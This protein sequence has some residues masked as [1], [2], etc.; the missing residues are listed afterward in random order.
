MPTC[1]NRLSQRDPNQIA[2]GGTGAVQNG[3]HEDYKH[4]YWGAGLMLQVSPIS[5]WFSPQSGLVGR[6]VG[7]E[8]NGGPNG[9]NPT[10]VPF[11]AALG[12][13]AI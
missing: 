2:S 9:G 4:G 3:F 13:S 10:I 8:I 12:N 5:A 7:S 1:R 11:H 6:T